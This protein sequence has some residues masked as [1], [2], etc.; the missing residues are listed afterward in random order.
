MNSSMYKIADFN[1]LWEIGF[2]INAV[3]VFFE[4]QPFLE[5]R[6]LGIHSIGE[7]IINRVFK[8]KDRS[9]VITNG[10]RNLAWG[11]GIWMGRLRKLSIIN[12]LVALVLIIV[13]GYWPD[14]KFGVTTSLLIII[15]LFAPILIIT[16]IIVYYLPIYKFKCIENAIKTI[17]KREQ[18][19]DDFDKNQ[20][21]KYKAAIE[22]INRD[23]F[24][25]SVFIKRDKR[26]SNEEVYRIYE[27]DIKK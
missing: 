9:Y 2:A 22:C 26:I 8:G 27:D 11:Y 15:L 25:G 5:K 12:S 6:F 20:I 19:G 23:H 10:W 16:G 3:F 7:D 14:A 24:F 1:S 17:M 4:L 13:S 18:A 21:R